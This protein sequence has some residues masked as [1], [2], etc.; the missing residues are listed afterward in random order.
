MFASA[1][2]SVLQTTRPVVQAALPVATRVAPYAKTW[3]IATLWGTAVVGAINLSVRYGVHA[4]AEHVRKD[5]RQEL[6]DEFL[7]N[8]ISSCDEH[9]HIQLDTATL[10]ALA[11]RVPS[12][13]PPTK[14]ERINVHAR[15]LGDT[16]LATV[17]GGWTAYTMPVWATAWASHRL[18][19]GTV[20]VLSSPL[21]WT[22]KHKASQSVNRVTRSTTMFAY[23]VVRQPS[24]GVGEWMA[25]PYNKALLNELQSFDWYQQVS[26]EQDWTTPVFVDE[27]EVVFNTEER[28][29][30]TGKY[31]EEHEFS[32]VVTDIVED[33]V[34]KVFTES[35]DVVGDLDQLRDM[36]DQSGDEAL[37]DAVNQVVGNTPGFQRLVRTYDLLAKKYRWPV[38]VINDEPELVAQKMRERIA[39]DRRSQLRACEEALPAFAFTKN[40]EPGVA[41]RFIEAFTAPSTK[42]PQGAQKG[43]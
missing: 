34:E 38:S 29:D 11:R 2:A 43:A 18:V 41:K 25:H 21:R 16:A 13:R 31:G 8:V 1:V 27:R 6:L 37:T 33:A 39:H 7:F 15:M 28:N 4:A 32:K 10:N 36:M 14:K 30:F 17:G 42:A 40:L 5:Q 12:F 26:P 23:R 9:G 19:D 20:F 24:L 35:D 3:G 22:G